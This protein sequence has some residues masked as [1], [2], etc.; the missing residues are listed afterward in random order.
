VKH[1]LKL[2]TIIGALSLGTVARAACVPTGNTAG[3][4]YQFGNVSAAFDAQ[5]TKPTANATGQV[6]FYVAAI[7]D[8]TAGTFSITNLTGETFFVEQDASSLFQAGLGWRLALT[9]DG[10][11]IDFNNTNAA[12]AQKS[13]LVWLLTG[14]DT[15]TP[16][17][18][19]GTPAT[20]SS[21]SPQ[22]P[23]TASLTS[24]D[25]VGCC[26]VYHDDG[27]NLTIT[28][29][30]S[31]WTSLA[32]D[33]KPAAANGKAIACSYQTSSGGAPGT[34]NWTL[35]ISRPW[36]AFTVGI[37]TTGGAASPVLKILQQH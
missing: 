14:C 28:H 29:P 33:F 2:V 30:S 9:G 12:S 20:G 23:T 17:R 22:C 13:G 31:P 4:D 26:I 10:A 18:A 34:A 21:T 3:T 27:D 1:L 5:V 25:F 7:N 15:T 19:F 6:Q 11:T 35:S 24:G 16:V 8:L 37:A 32:T 36:V